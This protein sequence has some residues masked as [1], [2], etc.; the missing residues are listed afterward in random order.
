[1]V[2]GTGKQ[3]EQKQEQKEIYVFNKKTGLVGYTFGDGKKFRAGVRYALD[4]EGVE[5]YAKVKH[6]GH[7]MLV[8]E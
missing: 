1:M 6:D 3:E 8:K 5:K 2:A 4:P 7:Q